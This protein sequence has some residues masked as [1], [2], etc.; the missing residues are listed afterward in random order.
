MTQPLPNIVL[1]SIDSLRADH[2]GYLGDDRGLT[3]TIDSLASEGVAFENAIAPGPQTF[4]SMPVVFTGRYR[5][6]ERFEAESGGRQWEQ[7]M[8]AIRQHLNNNPT[9][10]ERLG[11][12][13]YAT[14][15][16]TP[17][18][19]TSAAAG[20][21]RGFDQFLDL[22]GQD[23][24]GR[25][26]RLAGLIPG[27]D[28]DS[29]RTELAMNM[30]TGSSFFNQWEDIYEDLMRLRVRL[31]EP[32]FLWVFLLDT[33]YPYITSRHYRTETSWAGMY[34]SMYRSERAMRGNGEAMSDRVSEALQRSYRDTVRAVDGFLDRFRGDAAGDDPVL[35][36]HS[37][38]GESF[39]E[40][41]N[42]GH[43]HR[44]VYE[45]NVHVPYV[46]GNVGSRETVREPVSLA[47]VPDLAMELATEGTVSPETATSDRVVTTSVTGTNRGIRERR[48]KYVERKGQGMLFD[49]D[50]D[51]EEQTDVS[52][53]YPGRCHKARTRLESHEEHLAEVAG[54]YRAVPEIVARAPI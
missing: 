18:P 36:V 3:P 34:A 14:A 37:D 49:L 27:I 41:G 8:A 31:P 21:D 38:H 29:R 35:I 46:I 1:V 42:Y 48:F 5:P 39:G 45:E 40:H 19:W 16:V 2:C 44:Q 28:T 30:L 23:T 20:F 52:D 32:Y 24:G 53:D 15:A 43:H 6:L 54:L 13:G 7:R 12:V 11:E 50:G 17:N 22:S 9:L 51:P 25:L 26:A 47:T 33:H 10:P 4:S